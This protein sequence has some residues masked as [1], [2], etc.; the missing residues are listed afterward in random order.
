MVGSTSD[1]GA[2]CARAV[3]GA[4]AAHLGERGRRPTDE[5]DLAAGNDAL[6]VG[7]RVGGESRQVGEPVAAPSR[8]AFPDKPAV[9]AGRPRRT[10]RCTDCSRSRDARRCREGRD[11]GCCSP[12]PRCRGR[13]RAAHRSRNCRRRSGRPSSRRRPSRGRSAENFEVDRL[14][15][16]WITGWSETSS[17]RPAAES[18]AAGQ[19]FHCRGC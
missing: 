10:R 7:V 12:S 3:D 8:P 18:L 14:T 15:N 1:G 5:H 19:G 11:P 16:P 2:R 4:A 6:V 17:R 9:S 13:S